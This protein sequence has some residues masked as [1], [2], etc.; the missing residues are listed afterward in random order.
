[1]LSV[2]NVSNSVFYVGVTHVSKARVCSSHPWE[3][4]PLYR[5]SQCQNYPSVTPTS[6]STETDLPCG[7]CMCMDRRPTPRV[8][9]VSHLDS[10]A[11]PAPVSETLP[12]PM[13]HDPALPGQDLQ[14]VHGP[15]V[16]LKKLHP[17]VPSLIWLVK[18]PRRTCPRNE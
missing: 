1:M 6:V 14:I 18:S 4:W 3:H 5:P 2:F 10:A 15:G 7:G 12:H 11:F 9:L 17:P 8:V 16:A 13:T